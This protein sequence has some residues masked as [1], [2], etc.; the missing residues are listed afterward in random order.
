MRKA[1][2]NRGGFNTLLP[3]KRRWVRAIRRARLT[4]ARLS[5]IEIAKLQRNGTQISTD[6]H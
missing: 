1:V 2:K 6:L 5:S 3:K 4:P